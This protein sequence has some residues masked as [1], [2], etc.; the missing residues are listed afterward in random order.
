MDFE[1]NGQDATKFMH[2]IKKQ[3]KRLFQLSKTNSNNLQINSL[4]KAQEILAQIN[5]YPDWHALETTINAS[6]AILVKEKNSR[7]EL[8]RYSYENLYYLETEDSITTFL[9]INSLP[10]SIVEIQKRIN[11]FNDMFSFQI[12]MGIHEISIIFEQKNDIFAKQISYSLYDISKSFNISE[13]EAKKLFYIDKSKVKQLQDSNLNLYIVVSTKI[14]NKSDHLNLCLS[15]LSHDN[16][17][18]E[19]IPYLDKEQLDSFQMKDS[20]NNE[21]L[22]ESLLNHGLKSNEEGEFFLISKWIYLLNFLNDKKIGYL[23]KYSISGHFIEYKFDNYIANKDMI[24]SFINSAIKTTKFHQQELKYFSKP[25]YNYVQNN[26]TSGL[27]LR[28]ILNNG[29]FYYNDS[30]SM[31]TSHID[32]IYGKPGTGK[33]VLNNMITLS[34]LLNKDLTSIPKVAIIDIGTSYQGM[35]NLFKSMLPV[36]MKHLIKQYNI[37][38]KKEYAINIFDLPLGKRKYDNEDVE[39][40]S[41]IISSL[42][43]KKEGIKG[44]IKEA[45]K[46]L[47]LISEKYYYPGELII[48]KIIDKLQFK[49]TEKTTWWNIVDLLFSNGYD[50]LALKAQRYATPVMSDLILAL[51]SI[52]NEIKEIYRNVIVET[53]ETLVQYFNRNLM[54]FLDLY[55]FIN[56]PTK[57]EIND[58]KIVYFNLDK[59]SSFKEKEIQSYWFSSILHLSTYYLMGMGNSLYSSKAYNWKGDWK[60]Y[61]KNNPLELVYDYYNRQK[62]GNNWKYNNKLVIDELHR[63]S[64]NESAMTQIQ[65]A[66]RE[67]RKYNVAVSL[68]SQ[69]L[70]DFY[71]IKD[72]A[73]AF[74]ISET[75]MK[76]LKKLSEFGFENNEIE[77]MKKMKFLN[78]AVKLNTNRGKV[79]DVVQLEM[80][81]YLMFALST[82]S[83]DILVKNELLKKH[84]YMTMLEKSVNYLK[85]N[86]IKSFKQFFE[87]ENNKTSEEILK[88][89]LISIK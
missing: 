5:G 82:L 78:W 50:E 53:G 6:K 54:D 75:N 21:K 11:D 66:A 10:S 70:D 43:E 15:M 57:L 80:N 33:S 17:I 29:L 77:I 40:I 9:R 76:E 44:L 18:L 87:K 60:D 59:V 32:L 89:L 14:K 35:I 84:D 3:A 51:N 74:F 56:R 68:S 12:N 34:S 55:P 79:F 64:Q 46:S 20:T 1:N 63:F 58:T 73:S 13:E 49:I 31:R 42:F 39:R 26:D 81:D 30:S 25:N 27:T 86:Q 67:S 23:L 28:S 36:E 2:K 7:I 71:E 52:S 48:D 61:V 62:F 41:L 65:I 45:V 37:E 22:T 72:Y 47:N 88:N 24:D 8:E 85:E 38:N 4:S 16:I 69:L 19:S 83:E